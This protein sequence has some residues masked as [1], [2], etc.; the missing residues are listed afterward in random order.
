MLLDPKIA[1]S[2]AAAGHAAEEGE[3]LA[4]EVG[5][6]VAIHGGIVLT[7]AT[8]G[9][10]LWAARGAKSV[11]GQVIGFSPAHSQV[12]HVKKYR[13]PIFHRVRLRRS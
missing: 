11:Q 1:I 3:A 8:T 13:L 5:R 9:V 7:G 6:Q 4:F 2:G 12:E 10:P